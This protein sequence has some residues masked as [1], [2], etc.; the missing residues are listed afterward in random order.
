MALPALERLRKLDTTI[1]EICA[2]S[3]APGLSYGV[4]YEGQVLHTG[5]YGLSDIENQVCSTSADV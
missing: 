3:G 5:N 2:I 1:A 4:L